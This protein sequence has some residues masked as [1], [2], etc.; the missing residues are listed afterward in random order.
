MT[1][2]PDGR[3]PVARAAEWSSRIMTIS[4]EMVVPGLIGYRLDQKLDT[5]IGFMIAGFVLGFAVAMKHLLYL[6]RKA[7]RNRGKFSPPETNNEKD[8]DL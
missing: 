1:N 4:L 8:E 5:K 6:T 2:S 3:S 7:D